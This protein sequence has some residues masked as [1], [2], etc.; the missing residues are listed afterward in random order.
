[1]GGSTSSVEQR[2][3]GKILKST[4]IALLDDTLKQTYLPL[5]KVFQG[6][7]RPGVA[8]CNPEFWLR[9][10][11]SLE[12]RLILIVRLAQIVLEFHKLNYVNILLYPHK[13]YVDPSCFKNIAIAAIPPMYHLPPKKNS[14][15]FKTTPKHF[16]EHQ[17]DYSLVAPEERTEVSF[18]TDVYRLGRLFQYILNTDLHPDMR[19]G[20]LLEN[21]NTI[22]YDDRIIMPQNHTLMDKPILKMSEL[23]LMC[24]DPSPNERPTLEALLELLQ[25]ITVESFKY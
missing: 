3:D 1:M 2:V 25:A 10:E 24:K 8:S 21:S 9:S 19:Y 12:D 15:L 18:Q 17:T 22:I 7:G 16:S 13:I 20:Y 14:I 6:M 11:V 5:P 4:S 23:L